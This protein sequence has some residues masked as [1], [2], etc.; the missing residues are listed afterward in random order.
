M[1]YSWWVCLE[2]VEPMS[3]RPLLL[4]LPLVFAG[5]AVAAPGSIIP[6][7][8]TNPPESANP[9]FLITSSTLEGKVIDETGA[10]VQ[11]EL[12]VVTAPYHWMTWFSSGAN[13]HYSVDMNPAETVT[14]SAG[15]WNPSNYEVVANRIVVADGHP[16]RWFVVRHAAPRCLRLQCLDTDHHPL[17]GVQLEGTV[18]ADLNVWDLN[19]KSDASGAI[20]TDQVAENA[21]F[22][23]LTATKAGY[24]SPASITIRP[25]G[26]DFTADPIVLDRFHG[27]LSGRVVTAAGGAAPGALVAAGGQE[28]RTDARGRFAFNG[29]PPG[30]LSVV[31][32]AE[33]G[34]SAGFAPDG[35]AGPIRLQP[36]DTA[37]RDPSLAG[38]V[39]ASLRAD[40]AKSGFMNG[41][42]TGTNDGPFTVTDPATRVHNLLAVGYEWLDLPDHEIIPTGTLLDACSQ[43][44]DPQA[45]LA[46]AARV[47]EW[48][49]NW[50]TQPAAAA[51]VARLQSDVNSELNHS[52]DP[53]HPY[54]EASRGPG[55]FALA[56][57]YDATG[58]PAA[59]D[60]A[61]A[62]A[63]GWVHQT[64]KGP[65]PEDHGIERVNGIFRYTDPSTAWP[66][67][68]LA[69]SAPVL[70]TSPRLFN[71][72]IESMDPN[73]GFHHEALRESIEPIAHDLGLD[74]AAPYLA[75]LL[76][77]PESKPVPIQ[78]GGPVS[79]QR[80]YPSRLVAAIRAGG[81]RDPELAL[82]LARKIPVVSD[83]N[84][85]YR[86]SNAL[87]EAAWCLYPKDPIAAIKVW[88][89]AIPSMRPDLSVLWATKLRTHEPALAQE[90]YDDAQRRLD[91]PGF[92]P[93]PAAEDD[94][95]MQ[96]RFAWYEAAFN[97]ARAR[98]RLER[99]W[100]KTR[101]D[102]AGL[103]LAEFLVPAMAKLSFERAQAI[104]L[105]TPNPMD[106]YANM[107][108]YYG[109]G[110]RQALAH[111]EA[112]GASRLN[113]PK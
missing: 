77:L 112:D 83:P 30:E 39:L 43:M 87:A 44:T 18:H 66:E 56:A 105:A 22:Q 48:R 106:W 20:V 11:T 110:T 102:P 72:L 9:P 12:I 109:F 57:A 88:R 59:A 67:E 41:E 93:A 70:A 60:Q 2:C 63:L 75:S 73:S 101:R 35:S 79:L 37:V 58:Q 10:P 21:T 98:Y 19:L 45:R 14:V 24:A 108:E 113:D 34:L 53:D 52:L 25:D 42:Y 104:A 64:F 107:P 103:D 27:S 31:A 51:F 13:G 4:S 26:R 6:P 91:A 80:D 74:A 54:W 46:A 3:F 89:A 99:Q 40:A 7:D 68:V 62:T 17:A 92:T 86:E 65:P 50:S 28:T 32:L 55:V 81:A 61:F 5:T 94:W 111:Y 29:L 23:G 90:F 100:D 69:K 76:T 16:E 85:F 33:D 71:R 95:A 36:Q 47:V 82:A 97:P 1:R 38:P 84:P 96:I 8:S 49:P 78:W 15:E